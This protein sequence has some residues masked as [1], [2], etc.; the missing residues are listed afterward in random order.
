[1]H[2]NFGFTLIELLVAL[3]I[4]GILA[5]VAYPS[6]QSHVTKT[7]RHDAMGT[8]LAIATAMERYKA[9]NNFSYANA[10]LSSTTTGPNVVYTDKSPVS[11][12]NVYYEFSLAP[13]TLAYTITATPKGAQAS[14]GEFTYSSNGTKVW[15]NNPD[16]TNEWDDK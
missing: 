15:A 1:M 5:A 2:K 11:G 8:A 10:Q 7:R 12:S 9:R 13:S 6:Y 14:N 3:A 16:G 4:V